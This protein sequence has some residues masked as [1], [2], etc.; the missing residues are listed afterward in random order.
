MRGGS[1]VGLLD[2]KYTHI[3]CVSALNTPP[4]QKGSYWLGLNNLMKAFQR[5]RR[6]NGGVLIYMKKQF[7]W[8]SVQDLED[9][10]IDLEVIQG[11]EHG[12][13]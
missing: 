12:I 11:Q 4:I 9:K 1:S 2:I 10:S 6:K 13:S 5:G 7:V 8:D 3:I